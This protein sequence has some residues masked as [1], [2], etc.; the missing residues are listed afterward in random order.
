MVRL[1]INGRV[2]QAEK[3]EMLLVVMNREKISV[4]AICNHGAVEAFGACRLCTV[5]ITK[6]DWNGWKNYVTSCLYPVE[7]GLIVSTHSETVINLRKTLLDLHLARHPHSEHVRQ[8]AMEYGITQTSFE[9]IPDG[10]DCILCALCTRICDRMGFAAISTVGRG[11]GKEVAPP[12]N[13]PPPDCTGCLA[14]AQCCPTE[15]ITFSDS[16]TSREIWG[17][18]F[19]MI[20]CKECSKPI[21]TKDFA[22]TLSK[23]RNIPADYFEVCDECHRKAT[24]L[25][26]GKI[27]QWQRE[28]TAS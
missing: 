3:G 26:M 8:W 9:E 21:L 19:E 28:D 23:T 20:T 5:E 22:E 14:C 17:K 16:G 24:A 6:N 15:F 10:D 11:H 18:Q 12:L 7:D 25:T 27:S 2:V 1:T 4:P 13:E